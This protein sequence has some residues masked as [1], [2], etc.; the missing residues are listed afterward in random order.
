MIGEHR[1]LNPELPI[2]DDIKQALGD[3]VNHGYPLGGF[4]TAVVENNLM[5]AMGSADSYNR[6]TLHQICAYVY[7][8]MPSACHGSPERVAEWFKMHRENEA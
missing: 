1:K 8:D 3:Y 5:R 7:N 2:R 4:L 6:A